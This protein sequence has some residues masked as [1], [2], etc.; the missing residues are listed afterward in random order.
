MGRYSSMAI[1]LIA[2]EGENLSL[3]DA[4][5]WV[6]NLFTGQYWPHPNI[7]GL[8][9]FLQRIRF[10]VDPETNLFYFGAFGV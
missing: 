8:T 7:L 2:D 6:P 10:A 3:E 5:V 1:T 9:G 4:H